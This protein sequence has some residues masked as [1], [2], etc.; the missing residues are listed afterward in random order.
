MRSFFNFFDFRT[1]PAVQFFLRPLKTRT[2]LM[3]LLIV[4]AVGVWLA[5]WAFWYEPSSLVVKNYET[6]I[7]ELGAGFDNFKIVAISDVHGGSNFVTEERIREV[8]RRTNEQ[9]PDLIVLLGDF[10]SQTFNSRKNLKM[11]M[12]TI[13]DNLQG[14]QAKHGVFAVIGNHD[15]WYDEKKVEAELERVG[16]RVL[17]NEVV[18]IEQSGASF[19][20]IGLP[21]EIKAAVEYQPNVWGKYRDKAQTALKE[22]GLRENE[23]IVAI[24]HNPDPF[25]YIAHKLLL[26]ENFRLMLAGHT[27]GGQCNFPIVG[28]PVVP[29]SH[30]QRYVKGLIQENNRKLFVTS[31]IGMSVF[32]VR[33]RVPPEISVLTIKTN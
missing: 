16:Y 14:L 9:K 15:Y 10:V 1:L 2:V 33:F 31:G 25:S 6:R 7:P 3:L 20:L 30:G 28:A 17:E 12:A 26:D 21:D 27:H 13:A 23:P 29:S 11:P 32:P 19:A 22:F 18:R 4:G 8:V 24:T 5:S